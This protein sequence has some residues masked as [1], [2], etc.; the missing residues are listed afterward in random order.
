MTV[1]AG[2]GPLKGNAAMNTNTLPESRRHNGATHSFGE[3]HTRRARPA[4]S[5][6]LLTIVMLLLLVTVGVVVMS[7]ALTHWH[8]DFQRVVDTM[9]EYWEYNRS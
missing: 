3:K 1:P 2:A 7:P 4:V 8:P 6:R 9:L 5:L